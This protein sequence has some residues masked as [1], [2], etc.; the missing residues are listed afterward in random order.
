MR[1]GQVDQ[2]DHFEVLKYQVLGAHS[3]DIVNSI[4]ISDAIFTNKL[5]MS[6][7]LYILHTPFSVQYDYI[8]I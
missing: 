8:T 7:N 5:D 1:T 3:R 2:G 6:Y 4:I